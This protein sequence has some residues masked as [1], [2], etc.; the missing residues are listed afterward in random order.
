MSL[1]LSVATEDFAPS[2]KKAIGLA[3]TCEVDGVRLNARTE[4]SAGQATES[5]LRQT[6]LF[7]KERQMRVAGLFCPTRHAIYDPEYLEPR[8]D[9]IRKSMSL[10]RKLETTE[11]LI[12]CGRIPEPDVDSSSVHVTNVSVDDRPNPFSFSSPPA[13]PVP[14]PAADFSLMCEVLNDLTDYG[15]HVGC[16]LNL[17]LTAY[18]LRLIGRLLAEVKAGPIGIAF[19]TA[20]AV[21]S[22]ADV[23]GTYRDLYHHVNVVRAR[24]ALRNVD[25]AGTEVGVGDGVVDWVDFLPTLA[26]ADY[27]G[28]V[29]VERT[30][31]EHRAEDVRHGVSCLKTLLPQLGD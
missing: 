17:Q 4:V 30:G 29:C 16:V 25:G 1:R 21:M 12:R 24:D 10:A 27:T 18:D 15:N 11:V 22:G 26:E 5:G 31:G 2:L 20:T 9:I 28:W 19:D 23:I 13:K 7:V 6:L 3:A 8:V 14:S